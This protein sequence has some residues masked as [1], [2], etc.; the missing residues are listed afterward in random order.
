MKQRLAYIDNYRTFL[1]MIVITGHI[2]GVYGGTG[3][4]TWPYIEQV[5]D[6]FTKATLAT[7]DAVILGFVLTSFF[8]VSGYFVPQALSRKGFKK[9]ITDRIIKF[10]GPV[11]FYFFILSNINRYMGQTT[12]G[13]YEGDLFGFIQYSWSNGV[14]GRLGI[15]WFVAALLMFSIGY[16][17]LDKIAAKREWFNPTRLPSHKSILSFML[18]VSAFLFISR[19]WFPIKGFSISDIPL[20]SMV[21]FFLFFLLGALAYKGEWLHKLN[22]IYVRPWLIA[23]MF[24]FVLAIFAIAT[25]NS[26]Y[27]SQ[28]VHGYGTLHSLA[29]AL[30]ETVLGI[31]ILIS[32][33]L[34]FKNKFN[35]TNR[36][37]NALSQSSFVA[38]IIHPTIIIL[39][40]V[41]IKSWVIF[42]LLKFLLAS[43][44]ILI[45]VFSLSWLITRIPGVKKI[46]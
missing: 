35:Y 46:V 2:S 10:S 4:G 32:L 11:L 42:P 18:L 29:F 31:G 3:K 34:L 41:S 43:S 7:F 25:G 15:M 28:Q 6:A 9:F 5:T 17:I 8:F 26:G 22:N 13:L 1:I 40:T 44:I 20:G 27:D 36:L 39:I 30:W 16:A 23:V 14:Y 12:K 33:M 38:Y 37:T 19:I 45:I 21:L 24:L